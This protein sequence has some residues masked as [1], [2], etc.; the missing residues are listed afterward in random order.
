[1][2]EEKMLSIIIIIIF[3]LRNL[4]FNICKPLHQLNTLGWGVGEGLENS[5]KSL[6][7]W[8]LRFS[9]FSSGRKP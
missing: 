1:M 2:E 6:A 3:F 8:I 7:N 9:F 5:F 4:V